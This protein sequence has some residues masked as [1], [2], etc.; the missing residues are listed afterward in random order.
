MGDWQP[1][2]VSIEKVEKHPDADALDIATVLGDY[3]VI[4]KRDEYK[5]GDL[6][7]Y[8]PI[9]TI[10]PDTNQFYFLCPKTYEKYEEDGELKQRQIGMKYELGSVPEKNRILKAKR[11]RN[12]YSQGMLVSITDDVSYANLNIGDSI[13][14]ILQLKKHEEEEEDNLPNVKK[15]R[16]DQASPPKNW[17]IPFY[18]IQGLRKYVSCLGED[19]EI[20]LL[21]KIHGSSSSF[22]H[23]GEAFWIKSRNLYKK[24]D[25]EDMWVDIAIRY[26][27][28]NKLAEFPMHVFYGE[29]Y[30]QIKGFRYDTEMNTKIR[31]F[32]ILDVKTMQYLD[33]D[34]FVAII[35]KLELP[36]V[37]FLYRGKWTDKQTM[38]A[39]AEG[40]S[41]LNEKHIREGFVLRTA[42]ERYEPRLGSRMQVKLIS[43][44]YNLKK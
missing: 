6:A 29:I 39:F 30:G 40:K 15:R 31:F 28:A 43:E 23:D 5:V 14:D 27:L 25:P 2:V 3:P 34:A 4:V 10:V 8:L 1:Q 11:I 16:A 21:E 42:T 7:G 13:V 18:D 24:N 22:C 26:D 17:I 9:D 36:M 12:I 37:P 19:E 32:D 38:Y 41:T 33:Y 44:Q 35:Q 20:I